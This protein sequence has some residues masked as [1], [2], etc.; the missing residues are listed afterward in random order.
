M[1]GSGT[2][3]Q[4]GASS[5]RSVGGSSSQGMFGTRTTGGSV[6]ARN[7][8]FG[9]AGGGA[10][11]GMDASVGTTT[12]GERFLR[13]NRQ[14]GQFVGADV[15]DLGSFI[16]AMQ[17]GGNQF[18]SGGSSRNRGQDRGRDRNRSD[19]DPSHASRRGLRSATSSAH[20]S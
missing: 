19:D 17:G 8:S 13:E 6:G 18:A 2:S 7:R 11:T 1:S 4:S 5:G 20:T 12:G 16:G 3:R 9:A 14:P 10:S 15:G